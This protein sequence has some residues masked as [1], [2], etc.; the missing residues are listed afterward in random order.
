[1]VWRDRWG[2]RALRRTCIRV[3][4]WEVEVEKGVVWVG[5]FDRGETRWMRERVVGRVKARDIEQENRDA[6]VR[7]LWFVLMLEVL[8]LRDFDM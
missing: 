2:F 8:R 7:V 6:I 5:T 3:A 1:M 4:E